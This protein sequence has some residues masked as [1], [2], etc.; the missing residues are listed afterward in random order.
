MAKRNDE[1][2]LPL[3]VEAAAELTLR[4]AMENRWKVI[5]AGTDHFLLREP[6]DLVSRMMYRP[7]KVAVFLRRESGRRTR[8]EMIAAV[9]GFGPLP[10][11]RLRK[12]LAR[13][14]GEI[15]DAAGVTKSEP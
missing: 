2:H 15:E 7:C 6:F 5:D 14:R 9:M 12:I 13:L 3:T 10:Q 4:V 11:I 8:V 1:F